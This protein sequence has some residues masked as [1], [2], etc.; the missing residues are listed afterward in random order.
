MNALRLANESVNEA[1]MKSLNKFQIKRKYGR[2]IK[3]AIKKGSLELPQD[4]EEALFMYAFDNNEIKTDDPDEFN[5]W[6]DDNLED[7]A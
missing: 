4:A 3:K 5:D 2:V 6:L 7:F 1:F